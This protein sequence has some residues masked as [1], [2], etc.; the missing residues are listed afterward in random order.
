M[1]KKFSYPIKIDELKQN[2]YKYVLNADAEELQD[3]TEILQVEKVHLF[4]AEIWLKFNHR[5]NM[6]TVSGNVLADVEEKSVI[7]LQNFTKQYDVPFEVK[8]DTKATYQEIKEIDCDIDVDVPEIVENGIINLAD[9]AIEQIALS[10][11]AYP[12][13]EGESFD[14]SQ[15]SEQDVEIKKENPFAV[16]AKLKK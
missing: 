7:S 2:D 11:D 1:Q 12:R 9:V 14:F 3:V 5:Q 15:Y 13:G 6:L 4:K 10:L 16:L 8:Y